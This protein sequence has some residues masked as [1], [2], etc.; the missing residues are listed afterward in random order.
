M[1]ARC[2]RRLADSIC[3]NRFDFTAPIGSALLVMAPGGPRISTDGRYVIFSSGATDLLPAG[4]VHGEIY[5]KDLLTGD[6]KPVDVNHSGT[7]GANGSAWNYSISGNGRYVVFESFASDLTS[8]P[9]NGNGDIF[10]RDLQAGTSTLVSINRQG[11][12]GGRGGESY[13]PQISADGRFVIFTSYAT[14]LV[15]NYTAGDQVAFIVSSEYRTR[16]GLP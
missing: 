5:V 7:A 6:V 4:S 11:T 10:V 2:W 8:V 1:I 3:G 16:F 14:D 13:E 15:E 12:A 9:V